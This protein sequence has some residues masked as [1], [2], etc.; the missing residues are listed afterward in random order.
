VRDAKSKAETSDGGIGQPVFFLFAGCGEGQKTFLP[1]PV[2]LLQSNAG[3][4]AA[5][6]RAGFHG[7]RQT[8]DQKSREGA[9]AA[10]L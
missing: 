9:G 2:I 1:Y 4:S 5:R 10:Y 8:D 7:T 6:R 3:Y